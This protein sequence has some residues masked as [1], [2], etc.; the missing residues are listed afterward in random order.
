M[1]R[2]TSRL[3]ANESSYALCSRLSASRGWYSTDAGC[4]PSTS[5]SDWWLSSVSPPMRL[6]RGSN[7]R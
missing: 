7:A 6:T 5:S 3:L 4:N 1:S 2:S